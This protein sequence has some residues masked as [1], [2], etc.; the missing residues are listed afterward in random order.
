MELVDYVA[1]VGCI[2]VMRNLSIGEEGFYHWID[3]FIVRSMIYY[4]VVPLYEFIFV[5]QCTLWET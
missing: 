5:D 1:I 2:G 3:N 4:V